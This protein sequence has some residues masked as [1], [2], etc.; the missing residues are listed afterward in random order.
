MTR[1]YV[2][3]IVVWVVTPLCLLLGGV[4]GW[5]WRD[6]VAALLHAGLAWVLAW[7]MAL[8]A[9]WLV[10]PGVPFSLRPVPGSPL[11]PIALP[12]SVI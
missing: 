8:V 9:V 7:P 2:R 10:V 12:M 5:L 6:A 3:V 4:M 1:S 11:G